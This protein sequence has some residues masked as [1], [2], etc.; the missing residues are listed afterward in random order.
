MHWKQY[1]R[2]RNPLY[3]HDTIIPGM[4]AMLSAADVLEAM[5]EKGFWPYPTYSDLLFY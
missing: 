4:N 2:M 3:Y 1:Q 5:T